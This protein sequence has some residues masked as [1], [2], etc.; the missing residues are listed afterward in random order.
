LSTRDLIN[1]LSPDGRKTALVLSLLTVATG[2]FFL[3]VPLK[4]RAGYYS[5][6]LASQQIEQRLS[7][8]EGDRTSNQEKLRRW[9]EVRDE[10]QKLR[11]T[12]IY[13]KG[14]PTELRLDLEKILRNI[15]LRTPPI[16]YVYEDY[17]DPGFRKIQLSFAVSAPYFQ[18][19]NIIHAV[20]TLP[21]F[22]ILERIEF[23]DI[24]NQGVSIRVRFK[25]AGFYELPDKD[26]V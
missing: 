24:D 4:R 19:R 14:M 6:R 1:L 20:E 5:S 17:P 2:I 9:Q 21:K 8:L 11:D 23:L 13:H 12:Y 3:T 10:I 25:L 7:N 18:I 26:G 15:G 16:D 22:L